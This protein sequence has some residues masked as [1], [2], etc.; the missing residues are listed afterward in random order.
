MSRCF[1][2]NLRQDYGSELLQAD[3]QRAPEAARQKINQWVSDKTQQKIREL[4]SSGVIRTDTELILVNAI[5]LKATWQEQFE[6]Q[7]TD[8]GE[9]AT[10]DGRSVRTKMMHNE[11]SAMYAEDTQTQMLE[12]RYRGG[13]V[14]MQIYLPKQQEGLRQMEQSL[15]EKLITLG[16]RAATRRV[17][18]SLPRFTLRYQADLVQPLQQMGD[19]RRHLPITP[20]LP[21]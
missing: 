12:L 11:I 19:W 13:S 9:F 3:Y 4:I 15:P 8:D 18:L 6:P 2:R 16:E 1:Y 21:A 20:T 17:T 14:S 7:K 5:Y 10:A